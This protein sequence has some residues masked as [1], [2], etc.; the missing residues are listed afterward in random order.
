ML[1]FVEYHKSEVEKTNKQIEGSPNP[2]FLFG[3]HIFSQ[4]LTV[5]GLNTSKIIGIL[6]NSV[7]KQWKRLYGTSL[8][9]FSPTV[10]IKYLNPVCILRAGSYNDEIK[11]QIVKEVNAGTIFV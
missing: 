3:A 2:I 5:F 11:S 4:Y 8:K 6:D 7:Q 1:D 9:V 10:L